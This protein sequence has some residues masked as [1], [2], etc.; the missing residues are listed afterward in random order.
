MYLIAK[1]AAVNKASVKS[2]RHGNIY[3][4]G[5]FG[6]GNPPI[7]IDFD[8][9]PGEFNYIGPTSAASGGVFFIQRLGFTGRIGLK[10]Q[11]NLIPD[12]GLVDFDS[13]TLGNARSKIL[14]YKNIGS[15]PLRLGLLSSPPPGFAI[16]SPIPGASKVIGVGDSVGFTLR[17]NADMLGPRAGIMQIEN[18]DWRKNPFRFRVKG[19]VVP[20][21]VQVE[22]LVGSAVSIYPNPNAGSFRLDVP[23]QY[24]GK[25]YQL[26]NI[27]GKVVNRGVIEKGQSTI[28][29][30]QAS[31]GVYILAIEAGFKMKVMVQ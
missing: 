1:K 30:K 18:G 9:G 22:G 13:V 31:K 10:D 29:V 4:A 23:A 19:K 7:P 15:G 3:S 8:P 28:D 26:S 24:I 14:F 25:T 21:P 12:S 17:L 5:F 16:T 20:E 6:N 2:D 11:G 27:Q